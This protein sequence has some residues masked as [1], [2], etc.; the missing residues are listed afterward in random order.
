MF[1]ENIN[2]VDNK[3]DILNGWVDMDCA[4]VMDVD[5]LKGLGI[6]KNGTF[7]PNTERATGTTITGTNCFKQQR[8]AKRIKVFK[9]ITCTGVKTHVLSFLK[10]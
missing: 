8:N 1:V 9:E 7:D 4:V 6:K 5:F 3:Y 10:S 2:L